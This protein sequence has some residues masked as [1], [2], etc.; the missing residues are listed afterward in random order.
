[1]TGWHHH[2]Q[3][4]IGWDKIPHT[5]CLG[6]PRTTIFLISASRVARIT[7]VSH[8]AWVREASQFTFLEQSSSCSGDSWKKRSGQFSCLVFTCELELCL[9]SLMSLLSKGC[10]ECHRNSTKR[11][12]LSAE[13]RWDMRMC[14]EEGT[15]RDIL[16]VCDWFLMHPLML[17]PVLV[18]ET[19]L[20]CTLDYF[21]WCPYILT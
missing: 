13:Q 12:N 6:W 16:C 3:L 4:F 14:K 2:A 5:F 20:K 21:Y 9:L 11:E 19:F 7:G 17:Y 8:C 10:W 15:C 18:L 1:M